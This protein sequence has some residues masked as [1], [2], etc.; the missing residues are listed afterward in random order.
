MHCLSKE[1][2]RSNRGVSR[3]IASKSPVVV[4]ILY[5]SSNAI[6]TSSSV[7]IPPDSTVDGLTSSVL[8]V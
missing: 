5:A 8:S 7:L 1:G 2:S 6:E 4:R 3:C